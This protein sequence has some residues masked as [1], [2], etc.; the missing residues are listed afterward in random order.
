MAGCYGDSAEDRSFERM[1]DRY[2]DSHEIDYCCC[3][4]ERYTDE[5]G[6]DWIVI[7]EEKITMTELYDTE[8]EVCICT[9]CNGEIPEE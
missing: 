1:C 5:E 6:E 3:E 2:T 8:K 4:H 9:E 7:N